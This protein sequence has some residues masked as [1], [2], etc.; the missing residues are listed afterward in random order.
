MIDV[1]RLRYGGLAEYL[2][3]DVPTVFTEVTDTALMAQFH[4]A[5][6][7]AAAAFTRL[8]QWL[9]SQRATQTEDFALGA[10]RFS[11]MLRATEQVDVPLDRLIQVGRDDMARNVAALKDACA[12]F[13]PGKSVPQCAA[14]R[15]RR[16]AKG[17]R[18]GRGSS[19]ARYPRGIRPDQGPRIDSGNREGAGPA[20][21]AVSDGQRG[22]HRP[23]RAL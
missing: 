10:E 5:N 18:T 22:V 4:Q 19:P 23:G 20:I 17:R 9:E 8:D 7:E 2:T 13:A 14:P 3:K 6:A 15:Q 12:K 16:Q 11:E 1:G 21:T